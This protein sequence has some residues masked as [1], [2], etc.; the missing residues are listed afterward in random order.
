MIS[1]TGGG[2]S[3]VGQRADRD[4][5]CAAADAAVAGGHFSAHVPQVQRCSAQISRHMKPGLT[6]PQAC[7]SFV[8]L[9]LFFNLYQKSNMSLVVA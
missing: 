9:C 8:I 3:L 6:R 2:D 1:Q 5:G 4:Y 7:V